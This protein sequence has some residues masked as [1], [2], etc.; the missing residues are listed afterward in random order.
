MEAY[1]VFEGGGVK[2]AALAG[3]L[4]AAKENNID[5][6]GY[7]GASAGSIVAFLATIGYSPEELLR[8]LLKY[9]LTDYLEDLTGEK[10][11]TPKKW[12]K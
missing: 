2:G 12:I 1:A 3:A 7:G 10:L 4:A 6:V 5:F 11:T 8:A 9:Q